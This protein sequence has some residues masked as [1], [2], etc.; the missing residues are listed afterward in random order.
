MIHLYEQLLLAH[1][2]LPLNYSCVDLRGISIYF[3]N[4]YVYPGQ[5]LPSAVFVGMYDVR[6][7]TERRISW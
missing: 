3:A 7:V 6:E 1:G 5:I 2:L 4:C